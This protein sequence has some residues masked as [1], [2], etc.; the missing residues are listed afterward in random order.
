MFIVDNMIG[1]DGMINVSRNVYIMALDIQ[2]LHHNVGYDF[3]T[4]IINVMHN[5][6]TIA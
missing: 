5:Q 3:V 4:H 6:I 1:I 2:D